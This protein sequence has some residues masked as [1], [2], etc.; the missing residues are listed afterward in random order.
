MDKFE[1]KLKQIVMAGIGAIASTVEKSRDAIV[2]FAG[3]EQAK[4]LADKGEKTVQSVVDAGSQAIKKVKEALTEADL[5][6]RVRKEAQKL[7]SLAIQLHELTDDQREVVD[8]MLRDLKAAKP[9]DAAA[10]GSFGPLEGK[11]RKS[12]EALG[13]PGVHESDFDPPQDDVSDPKLAEQAKKDPLKPVTPTAPDDEHNAKR[14]Q[15]NTMNEHLKQN[16]PPDF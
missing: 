6:E 4:N 2:E 5:N 10:M 16:V 13:K 9:D 8:E 14:V 15:T 3:S 12:E 7:R 1:D 11:D